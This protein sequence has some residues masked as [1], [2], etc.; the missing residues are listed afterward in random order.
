MPTINRVNID[1]FTVTIEKA[2][3]DQAAGKKTVQV[4][5]EWRLHSDTGPQFEA[6]LRAERG[7]FTLQSDEPSFLGGGGS[8]PNPVQYCIYGAISCYAATFA[9]WAAMEGVVLKSLRVKA[10]AE[11]DMTRSFGIS[12]N[13]VIESL[14][15]EVTISTD[16]DDEKIGYIKKIAEERCPAY[17]CLANPIIPV[18]TISRE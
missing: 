18:V 5:G 1:N 13:P 15:W 3:Q 11:M 6:K 4:E 8:A 17:F 7:E 9:K 2:R 10:V 14:R 16:A 12:Q